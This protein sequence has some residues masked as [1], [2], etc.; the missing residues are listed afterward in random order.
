ME[1]LSTYWLSL[2]EYEM[3][4]IKPSALDARVSTPYSVPYSV[5]YPLDMPS[6]TVFGLAI[7]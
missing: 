6:P 7:L 5:P 3:K 2:T 1:R 4:V